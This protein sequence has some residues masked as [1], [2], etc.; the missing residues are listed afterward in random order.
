M[1]WISSLTHDVILSETLD[2]RVDAAM[3]QE[4]QSNCYE[5]NVTHMWKRYD[6]GG[7]NVRG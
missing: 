6:S 1:N 3:S 5:I 2:F 4:F 7:Q